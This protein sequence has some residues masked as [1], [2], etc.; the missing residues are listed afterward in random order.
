MSDR[1][2]EKSRGDS[3]SI[4]NVLMII[5]PFFIGL[6][7]DTWAVIAGSVVAL[8]LIITVLTNRKFTIDLD[9]SLLCLVILT[10]AAFVTVFSGISSGD[11][12]IGTARYLSILLWALLT[13]QMSAQK[14]QDALLC[15]PSVTLLML[16]ISAIVFF[17]PDLRYFVTN[18]NNRLAGFFQYSNTFSLFLLIGFVI[19]LEKLASEDTYIKQIIYAL[20]FLVGILWTG[21]RLT[22]GMTAVFL[23]FSFVKN[24]DMRK[25]YLVLLASIIIILILLLVLA[26]IS[27]NPFY[28]MINVSGSTFYGRLIYYQDALKI[29]AKHPLGLGYKGYWIVQPAL[30]SA[31][32]ATLYVHNGYLQCMLDLGWIAGI[33][34]I[35]FMGRLI[36]KTDHSERI[37]MVMTAVHIFFDFDLAY[38]YIWWIIVLLIPWNKQEKNIHPTCSIAVAGIFLASS[39]LLIPASYTS[40]AGQ[41]A[42]CYQILPT[43]LSNEILLMADE[44]DTDIQVSLARDVLSRYPECG[45]AYDA[46]AK[47]DEEKI[48]YLQ[49]LSNKRQALLLQK[50]NEEEYEE[51][52][53]MLEEAVRYYEKTGNTKNKEKSLSYLQEF[54]SIILKAESDLNILNRYTVDHMDFAIAEKT[55]NVLKE[56][57]LK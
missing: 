25:Y 54:P 5:A 48:D 51:Y 13:L 40:M 31:P 33:T 53:Q 50:Y 23:I 22:L 24:K 28:R 1:K 21:S 7:P 27:G 32:Y 6:A 35:V 20:V 46:L 8:L 49:M 16:I 15:I 34:L 47:A 4:L 37:L 30:Q 36:M 56:Y 29:I 44:D 12:F 17:F 55:E 9:P 43:S 26:G 18:G 38:Q 14:R 11:S 52:L 45:I 19:Y 42:K 3:L 41:Y 57:E 39:I 10:I 2:I